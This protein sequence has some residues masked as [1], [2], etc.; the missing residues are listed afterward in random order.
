MTKLIVPTMRSNVV[1]GRPVFLR[2][3]KVP[4]LRSETILRLPVSFFQ[5]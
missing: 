4:L 3:S 2:D 1:A 5:P